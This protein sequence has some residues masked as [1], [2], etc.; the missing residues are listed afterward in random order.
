M[1]VEIKR[2]DTNEIIVSGKYKSI[3]DCI[4]QNKNRSFYRAN[5]YSADLR[6]AD[7]RYADL[8][9]ADLHSAD[10]RHANLHSADL[11]H[12]NLRYADLRY[13]DLR[14]ADLCSAD[15]R[16]VKG[17][18]KQITTPLYGILDQIGK[19]RAYKL[20]NKNN[21]GI[22][23]GGIQYLKGKTV[24]EPNADIDE[25][26][27]CGAGINLAT[28]D[29]CIRGWKEGFKILICEFTKKDIACIPIGSDGKFRVY[30]CRVVGEKKLEDLGLRGKR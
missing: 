30:K 24:K 12:A 13:A 20:V 26:N 22:Y 25:Q 4:E 29:W 7:L 21:E 14:S 8:R 15:L 23:N 28:L 10:L 3:R 6:Y 17:I 2:R 27:Q 16:S 11:R 18:S 1:K 5:L 9:S 19:I